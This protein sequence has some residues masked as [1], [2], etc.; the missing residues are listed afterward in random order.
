MLLVFVSFA[1]I[2][3]THSHIVGRTMTV[4]DLVPYV[5]GVSAKVAAEATTS[6]TPVENAL[7]ENVDGVEA[8]IPI[9]AI[10]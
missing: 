1:I 2:E 6:V 3:T 7:M 8:I 5:C 4:M 10:R 9:L